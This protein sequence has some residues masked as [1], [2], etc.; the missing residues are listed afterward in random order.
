MAGSGLSYDSPDYLQRLHEI[1]DEL[2]KH[3]AG[4]SVVLEKALSPLLDPS[5]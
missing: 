4:V 3:I 5:S 1:P 2:V